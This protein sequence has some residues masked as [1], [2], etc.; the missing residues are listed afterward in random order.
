MLL[1]S[2]PFQSIDWS[3]VLQ[4]E[5][6]GATGKYF[7]RQ[8]MMHDIRIRMIEYSTDFKADHWCKKG[9]VLHCLDG[10]LDIILDNGNKMKLTKDMSL[11]IGDENEA[12][13]IS[14]DV[15]CKLFIVD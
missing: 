3:S 13:F 15:G 4:E 11:L 2:F 10:E 14:T 8:L 9:H 6:N 5:F 12:H 7:T 1:K